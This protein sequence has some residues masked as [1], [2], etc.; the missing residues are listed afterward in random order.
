MSVAVKK[1]GRKSSRGLKRYRGG[2]RRKSHAISCCIQTTMMRF[3]KGQRHLSVGELFSGSVSAPPSSRGVIPCQAH[4][5]GLMMRGLRGPEV[6]S[7]SAGVA[8]MTPLCNSCLM[9]LARNKARI[10]GTLRPHLTPATQHNAIG[11]V[12][13]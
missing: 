3:R 5:P 1:T 4:L 9:P 10:R 6:L 7:P 11:R 2:Y 12:I 8:A 13:I